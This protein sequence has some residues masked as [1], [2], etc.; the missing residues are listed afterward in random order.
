MAVAHVYFEYVT[1]ISYLLV[2]W[3]QSSNIYDIDLVCVEY[4]WEIRLSNRLGKY[5]SEYIK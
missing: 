2:L 1:I 4:L 5:D 3:N